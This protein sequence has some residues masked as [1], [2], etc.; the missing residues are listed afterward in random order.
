M[1][2]FVAGL[3]LQALSPEP[4]P[5][6]IPPACE[7]YKRLLEGI[8]AM[9]DGTYVGRA[10]APKP[11][12]EGQRLID[13][14]EQ[15]AVAMKAPK[16]DLV[17]IERLMREE[18]RLREDMLAAL[19]AAKISCDIAV[20]RAADP[21][22]QRKMLDMSRPRTRAEIEEQ[23]RNAPLPIAPPAPPAPPSPPPR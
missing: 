11:T 1:I 8:S 22:K 21:A 4:T 12:P 23:R 10:R 7:P 15:L 5:L 19:S 18:L 20:L 9:D 16:P 13:K 6:A 3:A 14:R 17:G 2:L